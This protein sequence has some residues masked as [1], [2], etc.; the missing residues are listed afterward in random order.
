MNPTSRKIKHNLIDSTTNGLFS[1]VFCWVLYRCTKK[2]Q[3]SVQYTHDMTSSNLV[4]GTMQRDHAS[5]F[6]AF[7]LTSIKNNIRFPPLPTGQFFGLNHV[8]HNK[9][10][11]FRHR[12]L[13]IL[14]R[15]EC[16]LDDTSGQAGW[17]SRA[18]GMWFFGELFFVGNLPRD[19]DFLQLSKSNISPHLKKFSS[20]WNPSVFCRI[21]WLGPRKMACLEREQFTELFGYLKFLMIQSILELLLDG[22]YPKQPPFGCRKNNPLKTRN[23]EHPKQ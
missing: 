8:F 16:D 18:Q 3:K 4:I 1:Q 22:R 19:L 17:G 9:R 11:D 7:C 21:I 6:W 10:G 12:S 23:L 20:C 2:D 5:L 13:A 15:V 14:R